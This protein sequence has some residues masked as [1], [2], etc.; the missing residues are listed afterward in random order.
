[1]EE[2]EALEHVLVHVGFHLHHHGQS[3]DVTRRDLHDDCEA[4]SS[5]GLP[6]LTPNYSILSLAR[7]LSLVKCHGVRAGVAAAI[8][9]PRWDAK[10]II[11]GRD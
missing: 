6:N 3:I 2:V 10:N 5:R 4:K 1:V 11:R 8:G 7:R 9:R